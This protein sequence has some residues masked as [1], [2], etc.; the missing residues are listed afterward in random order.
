MQ[1]AE[2]SIR[3]GRKVSIRK[4]LA[5]VNGLTVA[6]YIFLTAA[7]FVLFKAGAAYAL[8]QRGYYAIG[9]EAFALILPVFWYAGAR[10][11]ADW[12]DEFRPRHRRRRRRA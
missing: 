8:R 3:P 5:R 11:V 4:R 12:L 1:V 10:T 6:W 7:G 2:T 9:G